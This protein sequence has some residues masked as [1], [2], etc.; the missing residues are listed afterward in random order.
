M[1][2]PIIAIDGPAGSGKSTLSQAL[3]TRL[4]LARLDTGAMYRAVALAALDRGID[5]ADADAVATLAASVDL[6]VGERVTVDG[7]DVTE[8][9]RGPDVNRSVSVVAANP[10]VRRAMVAR[11][12]RWVASH[13][14]GVVVEGRDIGSVVLPS[15]DVKVYLTASDD[16]RARRRPEEEAHELSRRDHLDRTRAVSPLG[17]ADGA[18]VIDTTGRSVEDVAEEIAGWL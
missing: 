11:Q 13:A 16:E 17:V 18:H 14:D 4:G 1:S 8:A 5:P 12:R 2:G 10:G 3:S 7:V 15:A 9:I 6:G